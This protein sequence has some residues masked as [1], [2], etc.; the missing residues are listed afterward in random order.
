MT[1][2]NAKNF[3]TRKWIYQPQI[4]KS[5]SEEEKIHWGSG[6]SNQFSDELKSDN[7]QILEDAKDN[8]KMSESACFQIFNIAKLSVLLYYEW[9]TVL[10]SYLW[11]FWSFGSSPVNQSIT[12]I[13][14]VKFS[15]FLCRF[16][17]LNSKIPKDFCKIKR[18]IRQNICKNLL[19]FWSWAFEIYIEM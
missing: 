4:V 3:K 6:K 14:L 11:F 12:R 10:E 13:F 1:M 19:G 7:Q 5:E 9:I 2:K 16:Q 17:R 18:V 8:I 15:T